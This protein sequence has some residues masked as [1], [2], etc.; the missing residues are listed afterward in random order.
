M[1]GH[2]NV[3]YN[4]AT[5]KHTV[6]MTLPIP[7]KMGLPRLR[8]MY[9]RY[10]DASTPVLWDAV[11]LYDEKLGIK[12]GTAVEPTARVRE[13]LCGHVPTVLA[14]IIIQYCRRIDFRTILDL[15]H[16]S[17]MDVQELLH[18]YGCNMTP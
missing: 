8:K 1:F 14:D 2:F 9:A 12:I 7:L 15:T 6:K 4:L 17:N 18:S 3:M 5:K 16:P 13:A 10:L 11:I